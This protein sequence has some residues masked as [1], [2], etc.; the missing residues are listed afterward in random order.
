MNETITQSFSVR[1]TTRLDAGELST[2]LNEIIKIGGST[3]YQ[4]PLTAD[5]F[6]SKFITG[7]G[8][9]SCFVAESPN[10]MLLGFQWLTRSDNLPE[11]W[12]EIATFAKANSGVRGIGTALFDKTCSVAKENG[13]NTINATIRAD[14]VSGLGYYSKMGFVDYNVIKDAP[15]PDGK[16]VDRVQKKHSMV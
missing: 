16:L 14:N 7:A 11:N 12:G 4:K 10:G 8:I 6:A 5:E 3:A 15:L 1:P 13:L 2:L 9:V